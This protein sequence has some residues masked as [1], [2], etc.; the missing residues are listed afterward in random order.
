MRVVVADNEPYGPSHQ[1]GYNGVS[2]LRLGTWEAPNLFV[3]QYAGLN[4]E[5]FLSGDAASYDWNIFE[6][7]RAPMQ[8]SRMS[9]NRV[10]LHQA[11]TE[12]WPIR[13][14]LVYEV[15]GDAVD[16][17][18]YGT[19]LEDV[20]KKH[21]YIGV[22]FASYIRAPQDMA[23]HFIGRS[24]PGQ[25]DL[26]PRWIR[27]LPPSHGVAA[28]HRPAGSSWDPDFDQGFKISL[29]SGRSDLEYLYPFY[30]GRSGDTVFIQ[31]FEAPAPGSELR[32]AQSPSGGGTGNPTWDFV[33]F[34][35]EYAIGREFSFRMRAVYKEFTN[36]EEVVRT[37]ERWSGKPVHRPPDAAPSP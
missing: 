24:R 16:L 9:P 31:M 7:R 36:V 32:F 10:E 8:L 2:E 14:R 34:Q 26:T 29:A 21:G 25:G 13:S 12:H 15:H 33:H 35:R 37:Y 1:A 5:H 3:P 17:T 6:P 28:N 19:P 30:F 22:F 18:Y 23:I 4:L 20:W 11:R 27:H